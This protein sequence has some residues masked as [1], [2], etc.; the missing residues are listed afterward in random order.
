MPGS[1]VTTAPGCMG[2]GSP[3]DSEVEIDPQDDHRIAMSMAL[4]GLRRPGIVIRHPEVVSK[5]YPHFWR[6]LDT[7][8]R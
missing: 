8:V 1:M 7:L 3:P 5:S 4:L 6:D 2:N